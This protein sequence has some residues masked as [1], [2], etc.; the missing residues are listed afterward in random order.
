MTKKT[1]LITGAT[2]GIGRHAALHLAA[3]GHHVIATGRNA[4]A[5]DALVAAARS[6]W[7]LD[8]VRLDVTDAESIAQASEAVRRLTGGRGIDALVNNAGYGLPGPMVELTDEEVRAQFE[9][10]VFG[11][12]AVTR[13][14]AKDMQARGD[15]RIVNISSI[16]G[17]TSFPMF[18]AY[19]ATKYAVEAMS[20]AMRVELAPFGVGVAVVEPGPIRTEFANRSLAE[21][22]KQRT[23]DTA[24]GAAYARADALAA[25]ADRQGV[26]PEVVSR[27]IEHAIIARRARRRYVVPARMNVALFFARWTPAAILDF[28]YSRFF[29][30]TR[31]QLAAPADGRL[32]TA[33]R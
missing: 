4:A 33:D 6:D 10:N 13:S 16:G 14:F 20:D 25:L 30:L 27:A 21:I 5:L 19:H 12:L 7:T 2:A 23:R 24:Y 29:G 32:L 15:G 31:R 28:V 11:L 8:V 1:V 18:G 26:G 22:G 17:R 9:V 3:R